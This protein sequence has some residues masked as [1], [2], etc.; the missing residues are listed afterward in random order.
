M[1]LGSMHLPFENEDSLIEDNE[2]H[3]QSK[4]E[5]IGGKNV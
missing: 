4:I 2:K 3:T 1:F 5:I